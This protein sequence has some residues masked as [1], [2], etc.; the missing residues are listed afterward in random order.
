MNWSSP[1]ISAR[2]ITRSRSATTSKRLCPTCSMGECI[3]GSRAGGPVSRDVITPPCRACARIPAGWLPSGASAVPGACFV[4]ASA[5]LTK[6]H[7]MIERRAARPLL[8]RA[9]SR[10]FN[11]H[12][13]V[14]HRAETSPADANPE[15]LT[16]HGHN[17][18]F[19]I[20]HPVRGLLH[21][22]RHSRTNATRRRTA[23]P[24]DSPNPSNNADIQLA[25]VRRAISRLLDQTSH[26]FRTP[27]TVIKEFATLMR[28]GLVGAVNP[29]QHEYL[30]VIN[31]RADDLTAM[32][33]NVLDAGKLD[34]GLMRLWRQPTDVAQAISLASALPRRKA[35][36]KKIAFETAVEPNL[37]AVH[38]DADQLTRILNNLA[39]ETLDAYYEPESLRLRAYLDPG[40]DDVCIELA[41]R[42]GHVEPDRLAA[43][44]DA[45][46]RTWPRHESAASG[47]LDRLRLIRR[48]VE[49]H[50]GRMRFEHS[51]N[52]ETSFRVTIP[53]DEPLRLLDGYLHRS[54]T[55]TVEPLEADLIAVTIS[56]HVKAV[57]ANVVDEFL[58]Q[59]TGENDLAVH[60]EKH[61]W[62]LL[63]HGDAARVA[64]LLGRIEAAWADTV[65]SRPGGLL[66][67][68][69][70][71]PL[72]HW[73]LDTDVA[74]LVDRF[75]AELAP[76]HSDEHRPTVLLVDDDMTFLLRA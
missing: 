69:T 73:S 30:G 61:R 50:L 67:R 72:G 32:V 4:R 19:C 42:G 40:Q 27:L 37:P 56:P 2:V 34:A 16:T 71:T 9:R 5:P 10:F 52:G 7:M 45:V 59:W 63:L 13:A 60:V 28:D 62:L 43:I 74:E 75:R 21:G 65:E 25:E 48:L 6:G 20:Q 15:R 3:C 53:I 70:W 11:K 18:C 14:S 57:V 55:A 36:A 64:S 17:L 54:P 33:D 29:R 35:A 8:R 58:Q 39:A 1:R 68:V 51:A 66:P 76:T 41:I 47:S 44:H 46:E 23:M 22:P 12:G 26:D 38:A 31:D 24:T 49:L